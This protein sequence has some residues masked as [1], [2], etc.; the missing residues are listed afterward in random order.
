[1]CI[2]KST[3]QEKLIGL[4]T[5][6]MKP[7]ALCMLLK[8]QVFVVFCHTPSSKGHAPRCENIYMFKACFDPK[9]FIQK[10]DGLWAKEMLLIIFFFINNCQN[11]KI[12]FVHG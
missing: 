6:R 12:H 5:L 10:P 3:Q 4:C 2:L 1:M 8:K 7:R 9:L 11:Y